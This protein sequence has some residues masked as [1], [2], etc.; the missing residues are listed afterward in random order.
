MTH[1][2]APGRIGWVD[3]T[4]PDV[5]GQD[6]STLR[7][8]YV[9]VAGVTAEPL[10]MGG[11]PDFVLKASDGEPVAG[12]CHARGTNADQPHGWMVYFVVR[13]LAASRAEALRRGATVLH[14]RGTPGETHRYA[15]I[16]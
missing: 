14:D 7:D 4:L 3:L 12:V 10:D 16:R 5:H 1:A 8:F 13:D 15:V 9:A 6:A 2:P 11:Y